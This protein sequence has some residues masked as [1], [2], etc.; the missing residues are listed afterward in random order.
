[1]AFPN[2]RVNSR[3]VG[4]P[5]ESS[6]RF[7]AMACT[8]RCDCTWYVDLVCVAGVCSPRSEIM[9]VLWCGAVFALPASVDQSA[10]STILSAK[11]YALVNCIVCYTLEVYSSSVKQL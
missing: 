2:P 11:H 8:S 7:L 3:P 10:L 4:R 1:M 6:R 9:G 5:T